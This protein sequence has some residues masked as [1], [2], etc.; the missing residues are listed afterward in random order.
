M[1]APE[2]QGSPPCAALATLRAAVRAHADALE[3][4]MA[5]VK[6]RVIVADRQKDAVNSAYH[7]GEIAA[8]HFRI[9]ALRS[10]DA[11]PTETVTDEGEG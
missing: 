7:G 1:S 10:L 2:F 9:D 5:V 4:R 3:A 8:L 11:E 6:D